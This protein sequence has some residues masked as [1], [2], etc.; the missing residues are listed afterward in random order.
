MSK[1]VRA[2]VLTLTVGLVVSCTV[3]P[4]RSIRADLAES[5]SATAGG[6]KSISETEDDEDFLPEGYINLDASSFEDEKFLEYVKK[7]LLNF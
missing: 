7:A 2:I 5:K 3:L 1:R 6:T 4:G